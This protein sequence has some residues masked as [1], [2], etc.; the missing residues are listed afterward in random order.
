MEG[1]GLVRP[2]RERG[3]FAPGGR[4]CSPE[5]EPPSP[6]PAGARRT[7]RQADRQ[8]GRHGDR[9]IGRQ[10]DRQTSRQIDRQTD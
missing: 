5:T 7:G 1:K 9:Q 8:T 4:G 10:D 2:A 6:S 3:L